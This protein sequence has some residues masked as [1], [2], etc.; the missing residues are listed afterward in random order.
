MHLFSVQ[1]NIYPKMEQLP[2]LGLVRQFLKAMGLGVLFLCLGEED[3]HDLIREFALGSASEAWTAAAAAE[4]EEEEEEESRARQGVPGRTLVLCR[5]DAATNLTAAAATEMFS[6]RWHWLVPGP[7]AAEGGGDVDVEESSISRLPLRLDSNFYVYRSGGGRG[8]GTAAAAAVEEWYR[9]KSGPLLRQA[10]FSWNDKGGFDQLPLPSKWS[11]YAPGGISPMRNFQFG[12]LRRHLGGAVLTDAIVDVYGDWLSIIRIHLGEDGKLESVSG[13][14][15]DILAAL[16][17]VLNFTT[18][19][20]SV[21]D[22]SFGT[23]KVDEGG[24]GLISMFCQKEIFLSQK[25]DDGVSWD[26]AVGMLQRGEADVSATALTMTPERSRGCDFTLGLL[27][28]V[29]TL[30]LAR[31]ARRPTVNMDAYLNIFPLAAW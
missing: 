4:E 29:S 23:L 14:I 5:P 13:L 7:S 24:V 1:R 3:S 27:K 18:Q 9:V 25:K 28:D 15:P 22:A 12:N 30:A 16:G 26:G 6:S 2:P 17:R 20:V 31:D 8:G 21:E 19:V 11:R 10:L